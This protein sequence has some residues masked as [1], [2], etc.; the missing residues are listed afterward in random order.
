MI[1]WITAAA[2]RRWMDSPA[3]A[4][5]SNAVTATYAAD[6]SAH[7]SVPAEMIEIEGFGAQASWHGFVAGAVPFVLGVTPA[8]TI[9]LDLPVPI[10]DDRVVIE[11]LREVLPPGWTS[12]AFTFL[13]VARG[14]GVVTTGTQIYVGAS[15]Y[16]FH[17]QGYGQHGE[18]PDSIDRPTS[19]HLGKRVAFAKLPADVQKFALST[20]RDLWSLNSPA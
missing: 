13:P 20:Y 9:Q 12:L 10:A 1:E 15:A 3:G 2:M 18:S 16:P 19:R 11:V 7:F 6:P 8:H 17:P 4:W 14:Y 5:L